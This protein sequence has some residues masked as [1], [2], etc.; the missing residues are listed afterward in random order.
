MFN[1]FYN[2][3]FDFRIKSCLNKYFEST[4]RVAIYFERNILSAH[5]QLQVIP[6][7]IRMIERVEPM[8][9]VIL[10]NQS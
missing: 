4:G 2:F 10:I 7:P 8:F 5:F 6:I 1:K 3:D 9:K